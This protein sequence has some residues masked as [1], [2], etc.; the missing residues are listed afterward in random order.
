MPTDQR[1]VTLDYC[2]LYKYSY[3]LNYLLADNRL[4]YT[5]HRHHGSDRGRIRNVT[6][7]IDSAAAHTHTHTQTHRDAVS[8]ERECKRRQ[9]HTQP[10]SLCVTCTA[11]C[12]LSGSWAAG[13]PGIQCRHTR[14]YTRCHDVPRATPHQHLPTAHLNQAHT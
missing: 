2:A 7:S 12:M 3:L 13:Q 6:H 4:R 10:L 8:N 14:M 1:I 5:I 9:K 11:G